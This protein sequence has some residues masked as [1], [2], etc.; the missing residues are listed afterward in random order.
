MSFAQESTRSLS[1]ADQVVLNQD[2]EEVARVRTVQL[3]DTDIHDFIILPNGNYVLM[4]YVSEERDATEYGGTV[5]QRLTDGLLQEI[6]PD[7]DVL[8][9]WNSWDHMVWGENSGGTSHN[10]YA[11]LN[12]VSLDHDGNWLVSSRHMSQVLKIDRSTGEV[13]WRLGGAANDFTFLNDPFSGLCGQHTA[14]R[15]ENGNILVFD[16]GQPCVP[17]VPERGE[18]TRI[19]EY[20]LDMDAMTA[21]LVWTYQRPD[22]ITRT[23]GS[24]QRL[25]NGNT[26]IGW[27]AAGGKIASEV[28]PDGNVV[29][30]MSAVSIGGPVKSYRARRFAD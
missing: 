20:S 16:N 22:G 13:M 11:H 19:S 2:F 21:E 3:G 7:R 1:D 5:D 4:A 23:E 17:S 12:S 8:F 9:E 10:D 28:D 30:E 26:F 27:G 25:S 14:S 24:A 15:L 18:L 29:Y 6:T